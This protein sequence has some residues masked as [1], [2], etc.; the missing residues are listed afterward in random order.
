MVNETE[1]SILYNATT[2]DVLLTNGNNTPNTSQL[3][4]SFTP[5][6]TAC[7]AILGLV[8]VLMCLVSILGNSV[9]CYIVYQKP[10]MRSAINILLATLAMA[11]LL[12]ASLCMPFAIVSFVAQRWIFGDV[13]CQINAILFNFLVTEGTFVL[14]TIS[15]DRF[16]IIVQRKDTLTPRKAKMYIVISWVLS[17]VV[18]LPPIFGWG[19]YGF[20]LGQIQCSL[21]WPSRD[22][23]DLSYGLF[24]FITTFSIPLVLM[25]YCFG[26]I[27]RTVRRNSTRI[28]N[29][30][31]VPGGVMTKMHRPGK[32]NIDYS[33][34]TRAFTT[35]LILFILFVICGL[36]FTV[37]RFHLLFKGYA[38]SLSYTADVVVVLI[39]Y[40][41]CTLKPII[42]Y[43]RISKFREAC[44]DIM[45]SWCHVPHCL[46]GRTMRR[47]RPHVVYEVDKKFVT[48]AL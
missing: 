19:K 40:L 24:F 36:P 25:A 38:K 16:M 23:V 43:I 1:P 12:T 8:F 46:P 18:V 41:N 14:L 33:F 9:V 39:N 47:I 37:I 6:S 42:Y 32:M 26:S 21:E 48:S 20:E 44:L 5:F 45:P 3:T 15:V 4:P 17:F 10:A 22:A 30:P 11:D 31:P 27:L 29:H 2:G 35:I 34:K 13:F 28:Q 7:V